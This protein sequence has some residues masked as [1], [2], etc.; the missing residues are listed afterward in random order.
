MNV[1][2]FSQKFIKEQYTKVINLLLVTVYVL[3]IRCTNSFLFL[4]FCFQGK[5][6][7]KGQKGDSGS[8]GIDVFSV[9]KVI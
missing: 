2:F 5:P 3:N 8:P 1:V 6:G 9:A 4:I 7:D